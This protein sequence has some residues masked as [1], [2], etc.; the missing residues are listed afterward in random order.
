[1]KSHI[2]QLVGI[3]LFAA[4]TSGYGGVLAAWDFNES[5][6]AGDGNTSTDKGWSAFAMGSGASDTVTFSDSHTSSNSCLLYT[7]DAADDVSTV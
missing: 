5:D 1:M 4:I 2:Y 7:S 3:C 6:S